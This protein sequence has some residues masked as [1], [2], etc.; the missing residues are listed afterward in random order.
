MRRKSD[1]E[2]DETSNGS[3]ITV[4]E[5]TAMR[6]WYII[7]GALMLGAAVLGTLIWAG[8][9]PI[10]DVAEPVLS[11]V[12]T[13]DVSRPAFDRWVAAGGDERSEAVA[14]FEQFIADAGYAD[15]T[16]PWTLLRAERK[17]SML[18]RA[19]PFIMPPRRTWPNILPALKLVRER[20]VPAVGAVE[21]ASA[22]RGPALNDCSG[23]AGQS[24]HMTFSALDLEPKDQPDATASFTLLCRA[25]RR[26]GS[27]SRWG[28]GAYY[29]PD[30]PRWN[31]AGR[32]H[33]DGTG[34]R[35][36]GFSKRRAS[37]GC[38]TL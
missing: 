36:W 33:V 9:L 1:F 11:R 25:W 2:F 6:L 17:R 31:R 4:T 12:T 13:A 18:C 3:E 29:D 35:T 24:R 5:G 22:F 23:G 38:N 30:H 7:L 37:S 28:L 19:A 16:P 10:L 21:V 14:A 34:W 27:A 32:F 20:V 26:A 15:M 8:N